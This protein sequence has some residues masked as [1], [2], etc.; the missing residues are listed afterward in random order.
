M[1]QRSTNDPVLKIGS[2]IQMVNG[3]VGFSEN[4][5]YMI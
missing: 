4:E 3:R 2:V 1:K 5:K